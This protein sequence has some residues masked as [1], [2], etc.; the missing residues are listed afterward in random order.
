MAVVSCVGQAVSGRQQGYHVGGGTVAAV[1]PE[2]QRGDHR[3]LGNCLLTSGGSGP[4]RLRLPDRGV[5]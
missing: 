3:G 5:Q 4:A 1:V 2:R